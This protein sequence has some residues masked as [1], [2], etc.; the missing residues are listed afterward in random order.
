MKNYKIHPF[1]NSRIA[2]ID[3]CEISKQKHHVTG[4]VEL[5]VTESRKKIR[6]YNKTHIH[7]ISLNAWLIAVIGHT[8]K[9][10][11]T[12]ASYLI[13]KNKQ[14]IFNDVNISMLVEKDIHGNKVPIPLIIEKANEASIASIA[15][16]IAEAKS[17]NLVEG[18]VVLQ[19]KSGQLEKVYYLLPGFLRRYFWKF[20]LKRPKLAFRKMGNVALTSIGMMG[21][22]DGWFI[23]LSI[24]PI[25]FGISSIVKKP[26]VVDD[27]IAIREM[28][29]MSILIDHDVIDGANMARFIS[30]LC[31]N[32][33]NGI[34]L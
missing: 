24:H 34:F 23:P 5:D 6:A 10:Y 9:Q 18:D 27:E 8:I 7:K 2:S 3:I 13:S 32:I 14:I 22:V 19:R 16:Q 28:L 20:L 11:E 4:L 17:I 30:A 1:P 26:A 12:S 25:C 29:K 21:K 15:K 31:G 33:E